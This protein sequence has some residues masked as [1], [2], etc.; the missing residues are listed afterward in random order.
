MGSQT[1]PKNVVNGDML[2]DCYHEWNFGLNGLFNG[3]C[4]LITR[5]I[6]SGGMGLCFIMGLVAPE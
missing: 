1:Y 2:G 6:N 5:N 3:L 4:C